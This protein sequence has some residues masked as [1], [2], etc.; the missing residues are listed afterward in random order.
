[1]WKLCRGE[2]LQQRVLHKRRALLSLEALLH[3]ALCPLPLL[4]LLL[5]LLLRF[6]GLHC[7]HCAGEAHK[8]LPPRLP[9]HCAHFGAPQLPH[10]L[11]HHYQVPANGRQQQGIHV[12]DVH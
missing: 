1:M 12:Q 9:K 3:L 8:G 10:A 11:I 7:R 4:L 2:H 5:L 6:S